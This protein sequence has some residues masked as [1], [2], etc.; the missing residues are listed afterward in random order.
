MARITIIG[1]GIMAT[2]LTV[3]M[4]DNGHEVRVVGTHLDG[5]VIDSIRE[6]GRHPRLDCPLPDGLVAYSQKK[7]I[8]E[9]RVYNHVSK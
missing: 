5:E 9:A 1:A 8:D 4:R 3:P 7:P 6:T 2:A